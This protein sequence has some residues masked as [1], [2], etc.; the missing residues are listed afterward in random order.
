MGIYLCFCTIVEGKITKESLVLQVVR[1]ARLKSLW[2]Y[3]SYTCLCE[4]KT[5]QMLEIVIIPI[6]I[7]QM[8]TF[9]HSNYFFLHFYDE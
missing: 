4:V 7:H 9:L 1:L 6:K 8:S 5:L 3:K 2:T